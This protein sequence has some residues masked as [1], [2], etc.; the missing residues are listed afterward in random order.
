MKNLFI[1]RRYLVFL[2][3][4]VMVF[5]ITGCQDTSLDSESVDGKSDVE[6]NIDEGTKD[7][8]KDAEE[9]TGKD[10]EEGNEPIEISSTG[11]E[12][13][14]STDVVVV[15]AGASG[16]SAAVAAA[17][18]GAKVILLEKLALVGGTG[19]FAEGIFAV[20]SELQ[21]NEHVNITRDEAFK[22]IMTYS[23]WRADP[24][25]ARSFVDKSAST[26]DWLEK[27]GV[28]FK[29][30]TTNNPGGMR[31]WHI[32]EG[33]GAA[34]S[35]ALEAQAK[36]QGVEILLETTGK[37]LIMNDKNEVAG[38]IAVDAKGNTIKI[39]SNSVII[40]SGGFANNKEML[41]KYTKGANVEPVGSV[42]KLGEGIQMAWEIGAD[43]RGADVLQLYRPGVPGEATDSHLSAAVRQPHLWINKGGERF[44][45]E[46]VIFEWPFA[47]NALANQE[48]GLMYVVFDSN[49]KEYM[50]K[51]GID[52]GV[53]VMVPV[54]T[55]LDKLEEALKKGI[56]NKD[57]IK[58]KTIDELAKA[59]DVDPKVLN[60]TIAK[61]NKASDTKH[62]SEFAKDSKFIQPITEG[63]FYA[64]K[65]KSHFLGTLGGLK[66]NSNAEVLNKENKVI[67]RLYAA[68]NDAGGMYGDS[69]DL[70]IPGGTIGFAVNFGR[71]AGE[72]AAKFI[73]K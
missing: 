38:V 54:G 23:H 65:S 51:E 53:G 57:V 39:A 52:I 27:Q 14:K 63:P 49:T 19:N 33:R 15:G 7:V 48:D 4:A 12:I 71:I 35:K 61:Y 47:G 44:C 73:S 45:D 13:E 40:A 70:T 43:E 11:K 10:T 60:E 42:G 3:I 64:I 5:S 62:D 24:K 28:E 67:P 37:K 22:L 34:M 55:R 2:L 59:L 9:D 58:T 26:I 32:F 68:G 1:K 25:I 20:E 17:E 50:M 69:Y 30:L 18:G 8:A 56:D 66:I 72:N 6:T 41:E 31:T 16:L 29:N 46:T 21:R 36:K